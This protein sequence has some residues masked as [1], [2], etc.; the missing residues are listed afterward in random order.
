MTNTT[1]AHTEQ[2][3]KKAEDMSTETEIYRWQRREHEDLLGHRAG[4]SS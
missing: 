1:N 3:D 4:R 2:K